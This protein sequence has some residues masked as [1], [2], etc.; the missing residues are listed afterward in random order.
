MTITFSE[1]G[2][3]YYTQGIMDFITSAKFG[4]SSTLYDMSL[5]GKKRISSTEIE[6][7]A[8]GYKESYADCDRV[9]LYGNYNGNEV[10]VF[11][12]VYDDSLECLHAAGTDNIFYDLRLSFD[13]Y[14]QNTSSTGE[15]DKVSIS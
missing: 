8:I 13:Q 2:I 3:Q 11:Q 6:F 9:I 12:H 7:I 1:R 14:V 4:N 5:T 10:A 15:Y